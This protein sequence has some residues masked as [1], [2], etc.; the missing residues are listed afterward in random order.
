MLHL[1]EGPIETLPDGFGIQVYT[2]DSRCMLATNGMTKPEWSPALELHLIL[3]ERFATRESGELQPFVE[4]L[5]VTAW[6]H[7]TQAKLNHGHTVNFGRS[8]ISGS[9]LTHG[10]LSLPYLDGP[11]LELLAEPPTRCLWLLPITARERDFKRD[12]GLEAL[13]EIFEREELNYL[14]LTRDSLV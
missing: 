1:F 6:F 5:S 13:E 9:E 2:T 12:H 11:Q 7:N 14:A 8:I 4:L 3:P 10:L